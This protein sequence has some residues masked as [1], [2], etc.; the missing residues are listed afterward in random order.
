MSTKIERR[1]T[2]EDL[3]EKA[4]LALKVPRL[5]ELAPLGFNVLVVSAKP[6]LLVKRSVSVQV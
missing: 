2:L 5:V 4:A 6:Y 3:K 1:Y